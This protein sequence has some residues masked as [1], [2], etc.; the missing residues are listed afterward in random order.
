M[1]INGISIKKYTG[2]FVEGEKLIYDCKQCF[3]LHTQ[4]LW[5]ESEQL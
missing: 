4:Y 3:I 5:L 1:F 2:K